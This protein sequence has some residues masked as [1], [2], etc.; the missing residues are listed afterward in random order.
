MRTPLMDLF[1]GWLLPIFLAVCV[2]WAVWLMV[3]TVID[4]RRG[5]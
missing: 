2:V 4:R 5:K 1:T 3:I